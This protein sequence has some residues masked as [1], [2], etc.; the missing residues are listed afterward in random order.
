V[1]PLLTLLSS[2]MECN[3]VGSIQV[4]PIVQDQNV[5]GGSRACIFTYGPG[6]E[7][8]AVG[9]AAC[10]DGEAARIQTPPPSKPS[11]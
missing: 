6:A 9:T 3:P 11:P 4:T 8:A 2:K 1:E 7:L 5:G 10:S